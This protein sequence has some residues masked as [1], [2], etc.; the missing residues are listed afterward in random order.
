MKAQLPT[1]F[2]IHVIN[3][4]KIFLL[5]VLVL[6]ISCTSGKKQAGETNQIIVSPGL[7]LI[8]S[9]DTIKINKTRES[10]I[11]RIFK[12]RDT[13]IEINLG[14]ACGYDGEGNPFSSDT[15]HKDINCDGIVFSYVSF[16]SKD[17]LKLDR[18]DISDTTHWAVKVNDSI[19]LGKRV[20]DV[21]KYFPKRRDSDEYSDY[22]KNLYSYG[23][24]LGLGKDG[25]AKKLSFISV[26]QRTD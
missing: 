7:G 24:T 1:T 10:E 20:G 11:F 15:Y 21:L 8:I 4:F 22:W 9:G 13:L 16:V 12:L 6:F 2:I 19:V 25:T 18:I 3:R 5:L 14:T 17:S 23:I 26:F